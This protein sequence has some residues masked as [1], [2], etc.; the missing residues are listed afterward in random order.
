M[1]SVLQEA[2]ILLLTQLGEAE[3]RAHICSSVGRNLR[4]GPSACPILT[5][6]RPAWL[7]WEMFVPQ[8]VCVCAEAVRNGW[9]SPAAATESCS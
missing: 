3:L 7:T 9:T 8:K 5:T 6:F 4:V 2:Q 1:S